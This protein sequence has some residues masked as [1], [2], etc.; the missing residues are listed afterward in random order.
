FIPGGIASMGKGMLS[1]PE[2]LSVPTPK[3]EYYY[4]I[5][6]FIDLIHRRKIESDINT[7]ENSLLTIEI[8]DEI[9][10]QLGVVFPADD[11]ASL[12]YGDV[13]EF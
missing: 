6:A 11:G 2:D 1:V 5:K 12:N 7:H 13:G 4:E 8:M 10:R 9:R 3:G